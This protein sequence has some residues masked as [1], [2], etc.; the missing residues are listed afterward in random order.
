MLKTI[1]KCA[2]LSLKKNIKQ[3]SLT[4]SKIQNTTSVTPFRTIKTTFFWDL[5]VF[6]DLD[7]DGT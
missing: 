4:T 2:N 1:R 6:S 3:I 5:K 7:D